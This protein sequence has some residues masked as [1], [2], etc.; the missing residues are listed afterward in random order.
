M[1]R[2]SSLVPYLHEAPSDATMHYDA[3]CCAGFW[4]ATMLSEWRVASAAQV[5]TI[6]TRA[7]S[8]T[9]TRLQAS[10]LL[11]VAKLFVHT[12][13]CRCTLTQESPAFV[14]FDSAYGLVW[15]GFAGQDDTRTCRVY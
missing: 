4:A 13:Y 5:L 7:I 2:L 12:I 1:D 6:I 14:V 15:L 10:T 8:G 9:A 11:D 3:D